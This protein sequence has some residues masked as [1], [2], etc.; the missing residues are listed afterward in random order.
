MFG[1]PG[2][3]KEEAENTVE[4]LLRNRGLIDTVDIF[5]W[6]YA[7]HTRVEGVERIERSGEDWALEYA[8]TGTR[9]DTL[10]SEEITELASYWEEVVWK[11]A[12]R[13]LHPT[14]RMVSPWSLK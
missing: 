7:K 1:Y 14:Y 4:F 10:N 5:P 6:A 13:F 3:G 12:P 8:H 9:A 2:T 11:E